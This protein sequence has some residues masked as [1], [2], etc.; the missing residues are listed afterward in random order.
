MRQPNHRFIYLFF[1][2]SLYFFS[3]NV[4][5]QAIDSK[6]PGYLALK[7]GQ[8]QWQ[9]VGDMKVANLVGDWRKKGHF[10]IRIKLPAGFYKAPHYHPQNAYFTVLSGTFH[11]GP[12]RVL[13]RSRAQA[14][15]AGT[16]YRVR[17]RTP[18]FEWANKPVTLQLSAKGP[19]MT[20]FL[21]AKNKK[22]L[23]ANNN[24]M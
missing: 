12:G 2:L 18:H 7:P 23:K 19:W 3:S 20:I 6:G 16:F 24:P 5:A 4:M 17:A 22:D 15:P 8:L 10:I 9:Q 13:S 14:L 21:H 1:Y 11:V